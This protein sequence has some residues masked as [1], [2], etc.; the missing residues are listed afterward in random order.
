M[1]LLDIQ[2]RHRGETAWVFGSGAT[3]NY[4]SPEFF[5]DKLVVGANGGAH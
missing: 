1:L 3:M 4:L 5:D 2:N